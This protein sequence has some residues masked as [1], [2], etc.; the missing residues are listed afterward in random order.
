M[1]TASN[2]LHQSLDEIQYGE[3]MRA[4]DYGGYTLYVNAAS[5]GDYNIVKL[6]DWDLLTV[7]ELVHTDTD[8]VEGWLFRTWSKYTEYTPHMLVVKTSSKASSEE[9]VFQYLSQHWLY[10]YNNKSG[11]LVPVNKNSPMEGAYNV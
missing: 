10:V 7:N 6:I 9:Y 4:T 3:L 5:G 8:L 1:S 2:I 11:L